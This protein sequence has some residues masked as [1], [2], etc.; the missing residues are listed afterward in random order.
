MD[1]KLFNINEKRKFLYVMIVFVDFYIYKPKKF[2]AQNNLF[3]STR[4][5]L[6]NHVFSFLKNKSLRQTSA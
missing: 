4:K 6:N 2:C 5:V 3:L 1:L